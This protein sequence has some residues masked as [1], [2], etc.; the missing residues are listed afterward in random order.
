V[1]WYSADRKA[2]T[3]T[4]LPGSANNDTVAVPDPRKALPGPKVPPLV[5][6]KKWLLARS[7]KAPV[8]VASW[9]IHGSPPRVDRTALVQVDLR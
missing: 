8:T 1:N 9:F 5:G 2:Q 6:G 4:P 7:A 3:G